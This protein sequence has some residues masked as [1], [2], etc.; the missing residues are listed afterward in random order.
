MTILDYILLAAL[1]VVL[2]GEALWHTVARRDRPKPM[3]AARLVR[4]LRII[5]ALLIVL[6]VAWSYAGRPLASL[7]L[8]A[9]LSTGGLIGLALAVTLVG[10]MGV[11]GAAMK[12]KGGDCQPAGDALA[13][14]PQTPA[15]TR[16]FILFAFV[17]GIGWELL[18]RGFVMWALTPIIGLAGAVIVAGVAYALGHGSRDSKSLV[19]SVISS[20][21]FTI[22]F[23][24]TGSLW[25]L[26]VL[27]IA[28]PL[29][30]LRAMRAM[31]PARG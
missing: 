4:S 2:P 11:A 19:G 28:L 21:L 1:L 10:L 23:A 7:G 27:H 6:V 16:L 24:L 14:M 17:A 31:Q 18:Y 30:G 15:D 25:W 20:F 29:M 8:D 26:I 9:P 12:A 5:V 13:M 22:G 3:L